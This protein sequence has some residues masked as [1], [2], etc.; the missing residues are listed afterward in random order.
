MKY[1][2]NLLSQKRNKMKLKIENDARMGQA[3]SI[4][5]VIHLKDESIVLKLS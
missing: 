5:H 1:V 4:L 3:Q 2:V